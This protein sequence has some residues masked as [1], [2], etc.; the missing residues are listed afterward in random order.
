MVFV[1]I[2]ALPLRFTP[3]VTFGVV[4]V[5]T[6]SIGSGAGSA[7]NSCKQR[8]INQNNDLVFFYLNNLSNKMKEMTAELYIQVAEQEPRE[9]LVAHL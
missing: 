5:V 8:K 3:T 9:F 6:V 7:P 4:G 1:A 2:V